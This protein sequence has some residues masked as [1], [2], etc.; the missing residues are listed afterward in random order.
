[1]TVMCN[2]SE[3]KTA[4]QC[5]WAALKD[6]D[7]EYDPDSYRDV[8]MEKSDEGDLVRACLKAMESYAQS[9]TQQLREER[10]KLQK[11]KDYVHGRLD[12]MGIPV[13]PEPE[14]NAAHGCRI[15]G[16]LNIVESALNPH[17]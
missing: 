17:P 5:L 2:E 4:E 15:E 12:L 6:V 13:D 7:M 14:N 16:R 10:D 3:V 1:M 11:F 8:L 9:Q